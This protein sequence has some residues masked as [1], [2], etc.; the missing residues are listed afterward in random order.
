MNDSNNNN[1]SQQIQKSHPLAYHSSRIL[2]DEIAKYKSL[3]HELELGPVSEVISEM[4][5]VDE[6]KLN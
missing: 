4:V 2:D 3:Q 6:G 1:N 5:S